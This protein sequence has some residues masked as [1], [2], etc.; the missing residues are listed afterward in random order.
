M[1]LKIYKDYE[2]LSEATAVA[3]VNSIKHK[4]SS[5]TL[6]SFRAYT[7]V[8]LSAICKKSINRKD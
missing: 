6:F 2:A 4:T 7:I 8:N 3:M 1:E 5:S